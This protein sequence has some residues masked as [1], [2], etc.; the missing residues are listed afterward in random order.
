MSVKLFTYGILLQ[1]DFRLE[2]KYD[3]GLI[4]EKIVYGKM[5]IDG[6][7]IHRCRVNSKYLS[8]R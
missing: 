2:I 3:G 1:L 6:N 7:R 5:V 4:S 8:R